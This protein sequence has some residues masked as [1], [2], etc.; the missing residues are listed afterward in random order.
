MH[1]GYYN[2]FI[3]S[4]TIIALPLTQLLKKY[5]EVPVWANEYKNFLDSKTKISF[6]TYF[7]CS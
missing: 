6:G 1:I 2:F 3:H 7:N 4:F 5:G